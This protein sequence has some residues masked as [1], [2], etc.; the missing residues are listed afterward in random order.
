MGLSSRSHADD[1]RPSPHGSAIRQR[2]LDCAHLA[3]ECHP[4]TVTRFPPCPCATCMTVGNG[5]TFP[6]DMNTSALE[7][8]LSLGSTDTLIHGRLWLR[9][10][11]IGLVNMRHSYP[12]FLPCSSTAYGPPM[13]DGLA[14]LDE[15]APTL[16]TP[17]NETK[18]TPRDHPTLGRAPTTDLNRRAISSLARLIQLRVRERIPEAQFGTVCHRS[19][20]FLQKLPSKPFDQHPLPHIE[21]ASIWPF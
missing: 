1:P 15:A 9:P 14:I 19:L 4:A 12:P 2:N 3:I 20:L 21:T 17:T 6:Q 8:G 13:I 18:R 7:M 5:S 10:R 16:T 11:C